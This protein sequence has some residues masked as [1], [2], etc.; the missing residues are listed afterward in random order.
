MSRKFIIDVQES[1]EG[2]LYI[3]F[4]QEIIDELGLIEGDII[5]Y[6]IGDDGESI[7]LRK[8]GHSA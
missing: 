6:D 8:D 3:E 7:L 4:P 1:P 5:R 2:D